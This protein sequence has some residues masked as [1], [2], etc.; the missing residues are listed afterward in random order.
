MEYITKSTQETYDLARKIASLTHSQDIIALQGTLG[1]GKTTFTQG[2]CKFFHVTAYVTSPTFTLINIYHGSLPIYHIDLY[3]LNELE[4]TLDIG[5]EEYL[6]P[7]EGIVLVEWADKFPDVLP[8]DY[9]SIKI[10]YENETTR[11]FYIQGLGNK[12]KDFEQNLACLIK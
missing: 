5:I 9:I 11:C 10:T 6:P 12:Y 4:D 8:E 1:A 3:R 7:K 2:F